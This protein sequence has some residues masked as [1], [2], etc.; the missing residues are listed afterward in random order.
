MSFIADA[1]NRSKRGN[2]STQVFSKGWVRS[3]L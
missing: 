3:V 2:L 1:P